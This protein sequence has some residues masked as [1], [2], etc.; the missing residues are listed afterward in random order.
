ME[1][2]EPEIRPPRSG[3]QRA[4][5]GAAF[6][7]TVPGLLLGVGSDHPSGY[8]GA[9]VFG[10]GIIGA[11]F[12]LAWAAEA[13]QLDVSQGLALAVLALIAVL[14][15]YVVD[16]TI[17]SKAGEDPHRY[18]PLAL[19]NMT[20]SNR[21]LIGVGWTAVVLVA[22]WRMKRIARAR[23]YAGDL[24]TQVRL[25][26]PHSIEIGFLAVATAYSL[27]LPLKNHLTLFD[28]GVL[29]ALYVGYVWRISR[30][31]AEE[32]HLVG[33]ARLLGG[34]PRAQR[35]AAVGA[36][37][38]YSAAVILTCAEPFADALVATGRELGIS[39][40]LLVQW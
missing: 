34:L 38:V 17:A 35:R 25:D 10:L 23:G 8:G 11:A 33:P 3:S 24:D 4:A 32:P 15:E 7:A 39:T 37:L 2:A 13:L 12:L 26:R 28:C 31:P 27:T 29:V 30:S 6:A 40:F 22:A 5:I 20:G 14:P 1:W 21:L 16:F 19:A 36:M 9:A 18:A